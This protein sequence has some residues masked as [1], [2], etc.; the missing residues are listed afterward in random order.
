ML[1]TIQYNTVPYQVNQTF[2]SASQPTA[3]LTFN[4][5]DCSNGVTATTGARMNITNI[6]VFSGNRRDIDDVPVPLGNGVHVFN[7][8]G[9]G[10]IIKVRGWVAH[11]TRA[12]LD[13]Y[14]ETIK[15]NIREQEKV[16]DVTIEGVTRRY[17][18]ATLMNMGDIFSERKGNDVTVCPFEFV[19]QTFSSAVDWEYSSSLKSITTSPE[20]QSISTIGNTESCPIF[21]LIINSASSLSKIVISS[22]TN[23][24]SMTIE[25]AFSAGEALVID[26]E[27]QTVQVNGVDVDF[28]GKFIDLEPDSNT[29]RYVI[30]SSSHDISA[31]IK[32]RNAY[33]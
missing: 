9:R 32:H 29:I 19:F 12:E 27:N 2:T 14:L 15:K 30:T 22:D 28:T 11:D 18:K 25:R 7:I 33:I 26:C 24:Q 23:G 1:N 31:T 4:G 6:D 16:L 13:A 10:K 8:Y 21:V 3:L 17:P 5:F 20:T